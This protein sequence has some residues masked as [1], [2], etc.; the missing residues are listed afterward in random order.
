MP[1]IQS[2]QKN[3]DSLTYNPNQPAVVI[4]DVTTNS[5]RADRA[6]IIINKFCLMPAFI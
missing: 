5:V 2:Q 3:I 6:A 4:R 1:D